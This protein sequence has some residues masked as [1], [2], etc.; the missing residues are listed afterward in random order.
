MTSTYLAKTWA[1]VLLALALALAGTCG[2]APIEPAATLP[3]SPPKPQAPDAMALFAAAEL[4][5][6]HGHAGQALSYLQQA[7]AADPQ[8][9]YLHL[10]VAQVMVKLGKPKQAQAEALAA[11]KLN[12]D[13]LDGWQLLGGIYSSNREVSSAIDAFEKVLTL[14]P[15]QQE[16]KL[17]LG[18]LYLDDNRPERAR[19]VLEALVQ[20]RPKLALARYYLGQALSTLRRYTAAERELK[21]AL[22]LSPNFQAAMFELARVY[23]LQHKNNQAEKIYEDILQQNPDS[24]LAHERLGRLYLRTGRYQQALQEFAVLK[25]AGQDD[26]DVRI[27]IGLVYF[28]QKRFERAVEEFRAIL[29][30]EPANDRAMFYLG[31]SLQEAGNESESLKVLED[32]P[33]TSDMFVD[34]RLHQAEILLMQNKVDQALELLRKTREEKPKDSDLLVAMAAIKE[35]Q[36]KLAEAEKLLRQALELEPNNAETYFRLGTILDKQGHRP[37]A[38]VMMRKAIQLDDRHARALNY[39]GYVLA[40]ENRNLDEAES[41]IRRA[42]AVEPGSG[43]ILDSLGWVFYQKGDYVRALSYLQKAQSSGAEDPVI[44]EHIGDAAMKLERYKL[45][46]ESYKHAL[47]LKHAHPKD[48]RHKLQEAQKHL[49]PANPRE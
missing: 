48:I 24:A 28:E 17:F 43:F 38:M 42:L 1:V 33:A 31:V 41:L 14:D 8:S 36:G 37:E 2:C 34:A 15:E 27:K 40:E 19:R 45:A 18:S 22:G 3:T 32:V 23:E 49:E 44:S 26:T 9:G 25:G 46:V 30:D 21:L 7:S 11:V 35:A 29:A 47:E 5:M 16:A 6:D 20:Q 13:L 10:E 4:Q 39:V 12:P